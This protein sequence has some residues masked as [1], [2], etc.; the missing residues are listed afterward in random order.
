MET[1][2][3]FTFCCCLFLLK[4]NVKK[5]IAVLIGE[6]IY[7]DLKQFITLRITGLSLTFERISI[8]ICIFTQN[9]GKEKFQ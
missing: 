2:F 6:V 8:F 3:L 9:R 4:M 5:R 7:S 1:L